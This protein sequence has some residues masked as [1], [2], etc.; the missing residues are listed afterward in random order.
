MNRADHAPHQTR[1]GTARSPFAGV[2]P[3][4]GVG[5]SVVLTACGTKP[6]AAGPLPVAIVARCGDEHVSSR[7]LEAAASARR[8]PPRDVLPLLLDD[9]CLAAGARLRA[10]PPAP[11]VAV[12]QRAL[13]A[14]TVL[15]DLRRAPAVVA[16]ITDADLAG[17]R[18]AR[19][20]EL[21]HDAA[22]KVVHA[23]VLHPEKG[24][25]DLPKA[26]ER[27]EAIRAA[28]RGAADANAFRDRATAA[29]AGDPAVKVETLAPVLR[30]G[31]V[32]GPDGEH[33][34]VAFAVAANDL[35]A[36]GAQS[37]LVET[38]FGVHVLQA[39]AVVPAV[40][41]ETERLRGL[42]AREI[43]AARARA[44]LDVL[45]ASLRREQPALVARDAA[46]LMSRPVFRGGKLSP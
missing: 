3:W 28:V 9:A 40:H 2:T 35:P 17:V 45:L 31:R 37:N 1:R 42:V 20:F 13:L 18:E 10:L 27:A 12:E 7:S 33:Y 43:R 24:P 38:S 22:M 5:L 23:V 46:D 4:L 44:D 16:P 30:D 25:P 19:W 36:P 41:L 34:E 11:Q 14:R 15:E 32:L 39:I 26:R 6:R 8:A 29:A 21:D